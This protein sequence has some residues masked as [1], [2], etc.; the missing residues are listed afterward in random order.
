[1][2][3]L[4]YYKEPDPDVYRQGFRPFT[5]PYQTTVEVTPKPDEQELVVVNAP[6]SIDIF[7]WGRSEVIIYNYSIMFVELE[8]NIFQ[9]EPFTIG[10]PSYGKQYFIKFNE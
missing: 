7:V 6:L 4:L 5:V 10:S 8:T 1:M 9:S 3:T 2:F